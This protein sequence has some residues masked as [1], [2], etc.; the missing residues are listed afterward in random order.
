MQIKIKRIDETL[1]LPT[2]QTPGSVAF[3]IYARIDITIPPQSLGRIPSNLIIQVPKGYVLVIKD[4]SST[5][6][7]G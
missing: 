5:A 4:R 7:K 1:P 6:G 3:D 2:Y